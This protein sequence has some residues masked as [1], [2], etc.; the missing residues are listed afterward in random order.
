MKKLIL[1][2]G[3]VLCVGLGGF[4]AWKMAKIDREAPAIRFP[5]EKE[6]TGSFS[7]DDLLKGVRAEDDQDGDVSD[8]LIVESVS[9]DDAKQR[10]MVVYAARD[11]SNNVS[12]ASRIL[13]CSGEMIEDAE[14]ESEEVSGSGS[15]TP[16]TAKTGKA[17]QTEKDGKNAGTKAGTD[18]TQKDSVGT[19]GMSA[20]EEN[21]SDSELG[22]DADSESDLESETETESES[23]SE[24]LP[25]GSPVIRLTENKVKI[26]EGSN[27]VP[28]NYVASV[29][30]DY[31][32]IYALWQDIQITG[33]YDVQKAGTYVLTYYVIDS[34]G[35]RSNQAKLKL[36]VEK[37]PGA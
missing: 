36:T 15:K 14:T 24:I 3:I 26:Q 31:D 8:S 11:N 4:T 25:A 12:K 29:E 10:A 23:E 28:L 6:Y 27:F 13:E 16:G 20:D 5:E 22:S 2:L 34:A 33:D 30:D 37:K 35:N 32:N 7:E 1:A 17:A 21:E 19:D 9:Y 18:S